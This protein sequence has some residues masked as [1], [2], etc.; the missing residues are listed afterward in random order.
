M[1]GGQNVANGIDGQS[2]EVDEGSGRV[3]VMKD[4]AKWMEGKKE[5]TESNVFITRATPN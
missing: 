2:T 1:K 5:S 3:R 4:R